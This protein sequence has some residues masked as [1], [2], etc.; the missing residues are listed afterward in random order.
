MDGIKVLMRGT[1]QSSF[2]TKQQEVCDL[3]EGPHSTTL[4]P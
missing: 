1:P 3:E 4:A 2:V